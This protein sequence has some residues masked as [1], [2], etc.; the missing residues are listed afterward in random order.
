[1]RHLLTAAFDCKNSKVLL[2]AGS[3]LVAASQLVTVDAAQAQSR[4]P[5]AWSGCFVG[6][7]AGIGTSSSTFADPSSSSPTF[8]SLGSQIKTNGDAKGFGGVQTGCDYQFASNWVVG[9]AGDFSWA[10]LG[11]GGD[12]FFNGK[13]GAPQHLSS[14]IEEFASITGR[15]GYAWDRALVYGKGGAVWAKGR[16]TADNIDSVV[17]AS[18]T[19]FCGTNVPCSANGNT[20]QWGWTAGF[21]IEYALV[22][23]WSLFGE[24]NHFDFG[25]KTAALFVTSPTFGGD[26][27]VSSPLNVQNRFDVVK[28]GVNYRFSGWMH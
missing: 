4:V 26:P 16:V 28:F 21:G 18:T 13:N 7:H 15:V 20:N 27:S 5:Y 19:F 17:Q 10:D 14:R 11:A 25:T 9:L 23:N 24:Y 8:T 22:G 3:A 6:G 2:L 1:M 12:S